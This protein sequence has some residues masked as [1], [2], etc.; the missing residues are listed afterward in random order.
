MKNDSL[1]AVAPLSVAEAW[2]RPAQKKLALYIR[3][4]FI[5]DCYKERN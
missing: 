2:H 1:N 4:S 5:D 3:A